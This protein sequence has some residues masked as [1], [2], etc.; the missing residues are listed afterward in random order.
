MTAKA[1]TKAK[2]NDGSPFDQ[3]WEQMGVTD[4]QHHTSSAQWREAARFVWNAAIRAS[5]AALRDQV[6]LIDKLTEL[7]SKGSQ[8]GNLEDLEHT[9][10][11]LRRAVVQTD[12][13]GRPER[14]DRPTVMDLF[15]GGSK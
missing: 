5:A 3:Y 14:I 7:Q 4:W 13:A 12:F 10:G 11:A 2:D 8:K 6:G 1:K 9:G 15:E